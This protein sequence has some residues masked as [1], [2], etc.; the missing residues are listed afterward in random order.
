MADAPMPAALASHVAGQR[1]AFFL[2]QLRR[3]GDDLSEAEL[4][5]QFLTELPALPLFVRRILLGHFAR[6]LGD[7]SVRGYEAAQ[8]LFAAAALTDVRGQGW[9]AWVRLEDEPPHRIGTCIAAKEAPP[10]VT[11][12]P[13]RPEDA[14]ALRALERRCPIVMG[15][16]RVTYDRGEDYFAGQR[17]V[18]DADPMVAE[19]NGALVAV[20]CVLTHEVRVGGRVYSASY[21]HHTRI[22]PEGQGGG[23]FS[24]LQG[25]EL[26]RHA[27]RPRVVY[28]YVAVGNEAALTKV[29]VPTWSIRPE[30]LLIDCRATA[31]PPAGRPAV[32][33]DAARV[34]ALLNATHEREELFIPY[35]VERLAARLEREPA[36]YGWQHLRLGA[37]A[38]VGIWPAGLRLT[39]ESG[40]TREETVRALVLDFGCTPE[41][42]D[43]MI[44]LLRAACATLAADGFTHLSVF[45]SPG[46]PARAALSPLAVRV[47]PY[48]FN[49]GL[50]EPADIAS[51]G[52]YVDQLYF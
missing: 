36:L 9:R 46:S 44:A 2:D 1:L 52:L 34:V 30:R 49:M 13:A 37:S 10:G 28:S 15:D 6:A 5:A 11:L 29:P 48:T 38:V 19:R 50:P 43:E 51:R 12:R 39:R 22:L 16:V 14:A 40:A 21:L 42:E 31:G 7:F 3:G 45:S 8:P 24:A 35:T 47:E 41:A 23:L 18:G 17:L 32:P 20:H 27:D 26:E 33:A 4:Q 25:A